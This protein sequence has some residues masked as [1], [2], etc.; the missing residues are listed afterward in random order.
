MLE[1]PMD[2]D[3]RKIITIKH[4][5][6]HANQIACGLV[7]ESLVNG[8]HLILIHQDYISSRGFIHRDIAARNILVDRQETC[9]IGDFGLCR[10]I[11][12]AQENYFAHVSTT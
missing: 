5:L 3:H 4:H 11:G 1:N 2:K 10:E 9:K 6:L 8:K 7:S 12:R